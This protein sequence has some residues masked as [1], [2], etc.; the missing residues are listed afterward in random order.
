MIDVGFWTTLSKRKLEE[1]KLDVSEKPI[2]GKYKINYSADKKSYL[3]LDIYSFD[4]DDQ[5]N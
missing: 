1:W 3:T 4:V 5:V 2:I